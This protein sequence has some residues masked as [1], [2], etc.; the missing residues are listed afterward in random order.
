MYHS[1][2]SPVKP[3]ALVMHLGKTARHEN[4][5][6]DPM[7]RIA[8]LPALGIPGVGML[9]L[10]FLLQGILLRIGVVQDDMGLHLVLLHDLYDRRNMTCRLLGGCWSLLQMPK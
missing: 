10:T 3:L 6:P 2:L 7:C 4:A 1:P 5:P 8:F 9:H